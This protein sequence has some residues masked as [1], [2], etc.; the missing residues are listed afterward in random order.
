MA[1]IL[2]YKA[3]LTDMENLSSEIEKISSVLKEDI[4]V[5]S[6]QGA[7]H[8]RLEATLNA[9][10]NSMTVIAENISKMSESIGTVRDIYT[11]REQE[12]QEALAAGIAS[13]PDIEGHAGGETYYKQ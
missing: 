10:K 13:R 9:L 7:T 8:A 11:K 2:S 12:I 5:S 6:L 3:M 1:I 4:T